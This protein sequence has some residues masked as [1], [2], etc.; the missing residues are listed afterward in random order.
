[1]NDWAAVPY[2]VLGG[3]RAKT[4]ISDEL[5]EK[6]GELP[7]IRGLDSALLCSVLNRPWIWYAAGSIQPPAA[8]TDAC[9]SLQTAAAPDTLESRRAC[10]QVRE[11]LLLCVASPGE[12]GEL[13]KELV[14][15]CAPYDMKPDFWKSNELAAARFEPQQY[16]ELNRPPCRVAPFSWPPDPK[17]WFTGYNDALDL[18]RQAQQGPDA[19]L[20]FLSWKMEWRPSWRASLLRARHWAWCFAAFG[21]AR[22]SAANVEIWRGLVC[23]FMWLHAEALAHGVSE[24]LPASPSLDEF[25][26]ALAQ[27][28]LIGAPSHIEVDGWVNA[29]PADPLS[30]VNLTFYSSFGKQTGLTLPPLE[31]WKAVS[32]SMG[33]RLMCRVGAD[34]LDRYRHVAFPRFYQHIYPAFSAAI[35]AYKKLAERTREIYEK[36]SPTWQQKLLQ[37][38][39]RWAMVRQFLTKRPLN[40]EV[41]E[42]FKQSAHCQVLVFAL[43]P[44]PE[45][46]GLVFAGFLPVHRSGGKWHVLLGEE[47][48]L[49]GWSSFGGGPEDNETGAMAAVREAREES[50]G[51]LLQDALQDAVVLPPL[52]S[53]ANRTIYG[54]YVP[55][56]LADTIQQCAAKH[57]P[58][59]AQ[60]T[61]GATWP[62]C[63][64]MKD[65]QWFEV[66]TNGLVSNKDKNK[67]K[68]LRYSL[69]LESHYEQ[70]LEQFKDLFNPL[71]WLPRRLESSHRRLMKSCGVEPV[72]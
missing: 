25:R 38:F 9:K 18:L 11:L 51:Y 53:D 50:Y 30:L 56:E 55:W 5:W 49:Q 36:M 23:D 42:L 43:A 41:D 12:M 68:V 69:Q 67:D 61:P 54:V 58:G 70:Q 10:L 2:L 52:I 66:N 33:D 6:V 45:R 32:Y 7:W 62:V 37:E 34:P 47:R 20:F 24:L 29:S 35:R 26:A 21:A 8:L 27:V 64:E 3:N 13:W 28:P 17:H 46:Q 71:R 19:P 63:L 48:N 1:M 15:L 59:A 16:P 14:S 60:H 57:T 22:W 31:V 39:K 44:R 40:P 65:A 4:H 72:P